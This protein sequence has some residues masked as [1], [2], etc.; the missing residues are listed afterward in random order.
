MS[1][2][3]ADVWLGSKFLVTNIDFECALGGLARV[4]PGR[5]VWGWKYFPGP[6]LYFFQYH[7]EWVHLTLIREGFLVG[8]LG[9]KRINFF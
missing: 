8:I 7:P 6:W 9:L 5:P 2:C 4:A 3:V 1:P